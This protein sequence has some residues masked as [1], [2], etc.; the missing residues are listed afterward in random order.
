MNRSAALVEA[1]RRWG[2]HAWIC[3]PRRTDPAFVVGF[4]GPAAKS[5]QHTMGAGSSW[6]AALAA[7]DAVRERTGFERVSVDSSEMAVVYGGHPPTLAEGEGVLALAKAGGLSHVAWYYEL[8]GIGEIM[9]ILNFC[10]CGE[11]LVHSRC[12]GCAV[13]D[14][15]LGGDHRVRLATDT[16]DDLEARLAAGERLLGRI[17]SDLE[18]LRRKLA[19]AERA[20]MAA[21]EERTL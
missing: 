15:L 3:G 8:R 7:A 10:R 2:E 5:T 6:E 19:E 11:P 18:K 16:P 1:R 17:G 14:D 12:H 4:A 20:Q 13:A 9:A 21:I